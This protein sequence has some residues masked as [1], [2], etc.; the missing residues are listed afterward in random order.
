MAFAERYA[1]A[2][3]GSLKDDE[4]HHATEV[5]AAAAIADRS[6][7]HIGALLHRVKYGNAIKKTFEG[8]SHALATL[9]REWREIVFTKGRERKWIRDKDW[10]NI[11]HLF[12]AMADRIADTSLAHYLGG[13][14]EP[15]GGTGSQGPKG[16]FKVC[17]TCAGT[18]RAQIRSTAEHKLSDYEIKLVGEMVGELEALESSHA[19]AA[20]VLLRRGE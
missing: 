14:C 1:A 15:C 2:L 7:R 5:L 8:D 19:G 10:P 18:R 11:G 13:I 12:P 3:P 9:Q 20:S 17:A 6:A 16:L 4:H